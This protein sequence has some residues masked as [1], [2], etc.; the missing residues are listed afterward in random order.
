MR[1]PVRL[2]RTIGNLIHNSRQRETDTVN[3]QYRRHQSLNVDG[4]I[5]PESPTHQRIS[6]ELTRLGR[7]GAV[8]EMENGSFFAPVGK[9]NEYGLINF[10]EPGQNNRAPTPRV[11]MESAAENRRLVTAMRRTTNFG[12]IPEIIAD[13]IISGSERERHEAADL[14]LQAHASDSETSRKLGLEL[15]EALKNKNWEDSGEQK[16]AFLGALHP[17]WALAGLLLGAGAAHKGGEMLRENL[18]ENGSN[19]RQTISPPEPNVPHATPPLPDPDDPINRTATGP[20]IIP[21]EI[22]PGTVLPRPDE[23]APRVLI[24]P[25]VSERFREQIYYENRKGN[26]LTKAQLDLIRDWF[27]EQFAQ[28]GW[29]HTG[30]GRSQ[31]TG[32]EMKEFWIPGHGIAFKHPRTGKRGDGRPGSHYADL[33]FELKNVNRLPAG[34]GLPD[35]RRVHIQTVDL[36]K[37]GKPTDRELRAALRIHLAT[38]DSVWLFDKS[39]MKGG[40][41]KK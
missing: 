9:K 39:W 16:V 12:N 31:T 25:D 29:E 37:N 18:E 32:D 38:G 34:K 5:H 19:E 1:K 22:F 24:F 26:D 41:S 2:Q 13:T 30:G 17:A 4:G 6:E 11:S 33:T 15:H 35:T 20:N 7:S 28:H 8:Q 10:P 21:P 40:R 27:L 14:L 23:D 3:R 36:D